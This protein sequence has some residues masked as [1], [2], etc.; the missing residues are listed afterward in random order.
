MDCSPPGS[1]S[2]EFSRQEYWNGLLFP[3]PGALPHPEIKHISLTSPAL[4]SVFFTTS[5]NWE[6]HYEHI[7]EKIGRLGNIQTF[8]KN[9][10]QL[11]VCIY[12]SHYKIN[13][14]KSR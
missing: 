7:C 14:V 1:L 3:T 2:I 12:S 10:I 8:T 9:S 4:A 13:L 6:A 5:A 11:S